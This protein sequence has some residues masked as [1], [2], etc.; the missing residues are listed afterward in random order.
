MRYKHIHVITLKE[1]C[2]ILKIGKSTLYKMRRKDPTFPQPIVSTSKLLRFD[3][4][5]IEQ[6]YQSK[7][8]KLQQPQQQQQR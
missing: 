7:L 5:Q 1:I 3:Y 8:H 4:N 2:K 6:W